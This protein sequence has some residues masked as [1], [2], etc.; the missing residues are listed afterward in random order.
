MA[1]EG[2]PPGP[3]RIAGT[4]SDSVLV[5]LDASVLGI[6]LNRPDSLNAFD[7]EM[8]ASFLAAL[9]RASANDVRCVVLTGAGRAFC[10]GEDLRALSSSY[11]AGTPP[12][13]GEILRKRYNPAIQ[14]LIALPKPVVAAI[15]GVAAGAGVSV[16]LACDYR[17]MTEEAR[18]ILAF[19]SVGLV[20]DS[21]A[22]WLLAKYLGVGRA[23]SLALTGEPLGAADSQALGLVNRVCPAAELA[24]V[25]REMAL[26]FASG[27]TLAFGLIK[28]LIWSAGEA[29]LRSH[30]EA[31]ADAQSAA[32]RSA[33]HLEGVRAFLEKRP[34]QFGGR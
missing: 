9:E 2:P 20:P 24:K 6:T 21:G 27:P 31:E 33:D 17:V 30:L 16:A 19:A 32:G 8:G 4:V 18:L 10:A 11:E 7:D 12:D 15:N 1:R 28:R 3:E 25:T 13:L 34:P 22:T 14:S 29:P 26:S 5:D 23:L